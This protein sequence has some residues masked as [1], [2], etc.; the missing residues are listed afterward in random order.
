MTPT[1]RTQVM[2]ARTAPSPSTSMALTT[3]IALQRSLSHASSIAY[4]APAPVDL[5]SEYS[6]MSGDD[7]T[8]SQ[9]RARKGWR[10]AFK[11][12][13]DKGGS[14]SS[15]AAGSRDAS[16]E[17]V[18]LLV[19]ASQHQARRASSSSRPSSPL[20]QSHGLPSPIIKS[21][22]SPSIKHDGQSSFIVTGPAANILSGQDN[23]SNSAKKEARK[24]TGS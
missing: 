18:R 4:T 10:K 14:A 17:S 13:K 22:R 11:S 12:N 24:S 6:E 19:P 8:A 9:P 16:P 2:I 3:P 1:L 15:S 21:P 5:D 7:Q 20:V 23:G